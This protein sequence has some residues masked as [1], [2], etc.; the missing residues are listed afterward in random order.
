VE[1]GLNTPAR[2]DKLKLDQDAMTFT[3]APAHRHILYQAHW[4]DPDSDLDQP[5]EDDLGQFNVAV[6]PRTESA[7]P[8]HTAYMNLKVDH[9]G[10]YTSGFKPKDVKYF[11]CSS[12][13]EDQ[14]AICKEY[15]WKLELLQADMS[16]PSNSVAYNL[17]L[18]CQNGLAMLSIPP[19][20]FQGPAH[21]RRSFRQTA[22]FHLL[23]CAPL[24]SPKCILL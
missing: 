3:L 24:R 10:M 17:K 18:C 13:R 9:T 22:A 14:C 7:I 16:K 1:S 12:F 15:H 5:G 11:S 19:P 23:G 4:Q 8:D 6:I 21:R 20:Y 2:M